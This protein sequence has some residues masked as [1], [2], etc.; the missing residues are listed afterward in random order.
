MI[1]RR[2][3][4]ESNVDNLNIGPPCGF[5]GLQLHIYIYMPMQ[6]LMGIISFVIIRRK[7]APAILLRITYV[8]ILFGRIIIFTGIGTC[9]VSPL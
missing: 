7:I 8:H 6:G 9:V 3:L 2:F 4:P 5:L 1:S